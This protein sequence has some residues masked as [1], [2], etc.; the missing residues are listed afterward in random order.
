MLSFF[1][2]VRLNPGAQVKNGSQTQIDTKLREVRFGKGVGS[3]P[4]LE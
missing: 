4:R 2:Y 3:L 1:L